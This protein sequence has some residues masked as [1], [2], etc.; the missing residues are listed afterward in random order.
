MIDSLDPS[1]EPVIGLMKKNLLTK[2]ALEEKWAYRFDTSD[3]KLVMV[4][5]EPPMI[6]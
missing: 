6:V 3:F 2:I 5:M 1:D 4:S